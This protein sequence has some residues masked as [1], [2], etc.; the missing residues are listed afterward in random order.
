MPR[1]KIINKHFSVFFLFKKQINNI[2][3]MY[4]A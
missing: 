1:I 4:S 3:G 2:L